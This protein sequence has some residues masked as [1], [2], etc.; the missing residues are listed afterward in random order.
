MAK[1]FGVEDV[2][3][4]KNIKISNWKVCHFIRERITWKNEMTIS[5]NVFILVCF[6]LHMSW[7][8]AKMASVVYLSF[9]KLAFYWRHSLHDKKERI[10]WSKKRLRS[11]SLLYSSSS[12]VVVSV[13]SKERRDDDDKRLFVTWKVDHHYSCCTL[14]FFLTKS[15][16]K[17]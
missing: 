8:N 3:A 6:S 2:R 11:E 17:T 7:R 10:T 9:D 4:A 14:F 1:K 5:C 13:L 15:R 12:P 16:S